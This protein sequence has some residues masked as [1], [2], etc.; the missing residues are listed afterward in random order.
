MLQDTLMA[1]KAIALYSKCMFTPVWS[2]TVSI[3][4]PNDQIVFHLTPHN[5]LLYQEMVLQDTKG[6]YNV[7]MEGTACALVQVCVYLS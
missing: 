7:K 2:S 3:W 6:K 1:V 4:S 5:K